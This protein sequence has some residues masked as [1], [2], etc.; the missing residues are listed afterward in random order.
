MRRMKNITTGKIISIVEHI[1]LKHSCDEYY[2]T[3]KKHDGDDSVEILAYGED[4]EMAIV[5]LSAI[6]EQIGFRTKNLGQLLAVPGWKWI[7]ERRQR[8]LA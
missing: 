7:K 8:L 2:L 1:M 6:K 5:S 4:V 3:N